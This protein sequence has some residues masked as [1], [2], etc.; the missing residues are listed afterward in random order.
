MV[1]TLHKYILAC[2]FMFDHLQDV[3]T[4]SGSNSDALV[5]LARCTWGSSRPTCSCFWKS[6]RY[7][8]LAALKVLLMRMAA[9]AQSQ[10]LGDHHLAVGLGLRLGLGH[11]HACQHLVLARCF[12]IVHLR[13]HPR[14]HCFCFHPPTNSDLP[15]GH[16]RG[17]CQGSGLAHPAPHQDFLENRRW[18]P[19]SSGTGQILCKKPLKRN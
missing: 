6:S 18:L 3:I 12:P 2:W 7:R 15:L 17:R 1:R 14:H 5:K 19:N 11:R 16:D 10:L 8:G 4:R 13:C 9:A